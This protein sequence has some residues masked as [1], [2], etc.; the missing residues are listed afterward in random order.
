ML[1][2]YNLPEDAVAHY[3]GET[4]AYIKEQRE[5]FAPQAHPLDEEL[6]EIFKP[7]FSEVILKNTLFYL[8]QDGPL[9]APPFLE[10]MRAKGVPFPLE[11]LQAITFIDVVV[12][13]TPLVA[14]VKFHEFVHAV[15]YQKMGYKQFANKYVRGLLSK[16]S[17]EKIPLEVNARILDESFSKNPTQSFSV[18][19]E[20]QRWINDNRF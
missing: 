12:F 11:R 19:Q 2:L 8:K 6:M 13:Y 20:V 4:A 1:Y 7:F 5:V 15:Q 10:E 16:G 17:Y 9:E 18:E 14:R 3:V